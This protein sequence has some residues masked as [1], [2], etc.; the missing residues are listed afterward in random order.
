MKPIF[1]GPVIFVADMK[2]S[3]P[4]YTEV[5]EQEELFAVGD[6]Y[7]A[8]KGFALWTA[9][10]ALSMMHKTLPDG[11]D[12]PQGRNNLELYF[13]TPALEA[14][15]ENL[16]EHDV[17]LLNNIHEQPWGQRAF[18]I[19]DPDGH[20]IEFAEPMSV[21]AQRLL[22]QGYSPQEIADKTMTELDEVKRLLDS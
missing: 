9:R 4:F 20:I 13:E 18:R 6:A 1:E 14:A 19:L 12:T 3:R 16:R 10:D 5:L 8:Y 15:L 21:V 11:T 2:D 17:A 22:N 7:T